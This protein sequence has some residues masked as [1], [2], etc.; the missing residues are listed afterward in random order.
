MPGLFNQDCLIF[1][2][3][4]IGTCYLNANVYTKIPNT[5]CDGWAKTSLEDCKK[6]CI[7]N[8]LPSGCSEGKPTSG[9]K[10]VFWHDNPD[11]QPGWCQLA[12]DGCM[13]QS[14]Y[15]SNSYDSYIIWEKPGKDINLQSVAYLYTVWPVYNVK[16]LCFRGWEW[17]REGGHSHSHFNIWLLWYKDIVIWIWS[18]YLH[19]LQNANTLNLEVF[20]FIT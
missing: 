4:I 8:E 19:W 9:C 2:F 1:K 15:N 11:W 14:E 3:W 12:E 6:K 5:P 7:N 13:T 10:F 20:N 18:W 16:C 17:G